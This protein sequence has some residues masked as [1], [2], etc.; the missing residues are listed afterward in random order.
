MSNYIKNLISTSGW[1]DVEKM[2]NESIR[3]CENQSNI[4]GELNNETYAREGRANVIAAKK[5]KE[6]LNKIRLAGGQVVKDKIKY[7]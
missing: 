7:T 6:L 5:M 3:Q 4:S 1:K 2:F